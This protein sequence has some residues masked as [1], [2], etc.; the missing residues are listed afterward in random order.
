M[1]GCNNQKSF[2]GVRFIKLIGNTDRFVEIVN[3]GK[4]SGSVVAVTGPVDC[5]TF[6]YQK[7]SPVG[8]IE[9][10]Y[11]RFCNLRQSKVVGFTVDSIGKRRTATPWLSGSTTVLLREKNFFA[12]L[13]GRNSIL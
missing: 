6:N 8:G 4:C 13:F 7:E 3:F 10:P 1:V 9:M 11:G 2:V 5:T 12:P